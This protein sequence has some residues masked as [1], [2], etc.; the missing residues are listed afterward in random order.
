MVGLAG[1]PA[2]LAEPSARS[3]QLSYG[4]SDSGILAQRHCETRVM[5]T[6]ERNPVKL[7]PVLEISLDSVESA[8]AAQRGGA[9]RVELCANL[10]E[11]G[12]TP[13]AG[14]IAT[15]RRETKIGLHVM[16]RPRGGDFHYSAEEFEV[17]RRDVLMA[18]QLR[19]DGVAL[20]I[21]SSDGTVDVKRTRELVE[22]ARPMPV[23]FHRAFDMTANL[24]DA[25]N[26]AIESGAA[27]ILTSGGEVAAEN[28]LDTIRGLVQAAGN[29]ITIMVCGGVR[30][31]NIRRIVTATGVREI[32]VGHG[33]VEIAAPSGMKYQNEKLSMG[34]APDRE[35]TH[36]AVSEER[37]RNL[38]RA[39]E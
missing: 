18:K 24:R 20:G 2:N 8:V 27:R 16:I 4:P 3:S 39:L 33:G 9:G 1:S 12:T 7:N 31:H 26:R 17:M 15:V 35:Y 25:I 19:A 22:L 13:S 10:P 34:T 30:E 29:R 5:A 6:L 38:V 11:G 28:A 23:T 37:V 21:L 14:M 36:F 32:H